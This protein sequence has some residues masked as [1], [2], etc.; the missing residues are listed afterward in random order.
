MFASFNFPSLG[1]FFF[2]FFFCFCF[3]RRYD[4]VWTDPDIAWLQNPL[5]LLAAIESDFVVQSNAPS[6][7]EVSNGK[8]RINSGFYSASIHL[9]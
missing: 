5:P 3:D 8:L 9:T 7:E 2:V 6:T 1:G 4:V